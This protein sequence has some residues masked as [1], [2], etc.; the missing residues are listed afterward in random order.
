[1]DGEYVRQSFRSISK[2]SASNFYF[3]GLYLSICRGGA[4]L[5]PPPVPDDGLTLYVMF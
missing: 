2:S 1:M 4:I 5:P 3:V